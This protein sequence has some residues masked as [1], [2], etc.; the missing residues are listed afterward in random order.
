MTPKK[1]STER[2][3]ALASAFVAPTTEPKAGRRHI[4]AGLFA[5]IGGLELGFSRSGHE[6][7]L[8]C[9]I[10]P[11][12]AA[13][14]RDRFP[15]I[16]V[17]DDVCTLDA[18]PEDVSLVVAG[19]PCQDLSQAGK[20]VGIE[21][22]R[23]GLVG[24]VFRLIRER[25]VGTVVLE[26]VPFMLR[27]ASGKAMDVITS[28]FESMGYAW[29]YRTVD[30]LAFGRPQRRERVYFVASRELDPRSV[31]FADESG[32]HQNQLDWNNVA[33]GFYWTEGIRGLG[34]AVDAVPTLKGG[35]TI[36]IPSPPAIVF[37]DGRIVTPDIRDAERLQGFEADWTTPS[38]NLTRAGHRWKL[39]GNAV[40]VEAATWL[41]RRLAE[42]GTVQ[43]LDEWLMKA[44]RAWPSAAY[45]VGMGRIGVAASTYPVATSR[46]GLAEFLEYE[47]TP[48]S[49]RATLGF[50]ERCSRGNLRFPKGFIEKIEAHARRLEVPA[51][52]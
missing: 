32:T 14:L 20:T 3:L 41:G 15:G 12:A 27:L 23:S 37:P 50:L 29:A 43:P 38:R 28:T 31:L 11:G 21:G 2:Q 13:V 46:K 30:A 8:L 39:V 10:E 6:T 26:N 47:P 22:S 34:W 4:V 19:F 24:E 42:P 33:C 36:G 1:K 35:S 40:S 9:E 51:A 49:L 7:A 45:N 16:R 17:H 44:G 48:L 5:G 18:L 25:R 52:A